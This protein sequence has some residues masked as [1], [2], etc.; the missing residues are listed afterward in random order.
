MLHSKHTCF[1]DD[2]FNKICIFP[3]EYICVFLLYDTHLMSTNLWNNKMVKI[4]YLEYLGTK[5]LI[6]RFK[7]IGCR[8]HLRTMNNLLISTFWPYCSQFSNLDKGHWYIGD[9][10]RNYDIHTMFVSEEARRRIGLSHATTPSWISIFKQHRILWRK[11]RNTF[12]ANLSF[13]LK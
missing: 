5:Q 4:C 12:E 1:Q 10:L 8:R 2:L 6:S 7:Y 9:S 3:A 13:H 11:H